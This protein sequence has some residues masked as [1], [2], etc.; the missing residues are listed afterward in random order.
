MHTFNEWVSSKYKRPRCN[1]FHF[2]FLCKF[3]DCSTHCNHTSKSSIKANHKC[4]FVLDWFSFLLF[5]F[6]HLSKYNINCICIIIQNCE[7]TKLFKKR[8]L[9]ISSRLFLTWHSFSTTK[10]QFSDSSIVSRR[11]ISSSITSDSSTSSISSRT[12]DC[13][14]GSKRI[15]DNHNICTISS[16]STFSSK[17]WIWICCCWT[18]KTRSSSISSVS[19]ISTNCWI[20]FKI[21]CSYYKSIHI[22]DCISS[23]STIY[24]SRHSR[25]HTVYYST[26]SISSFQ[27]SFSS[28]SSTSNIS[29]TYISSCLSISSSSST[30]SI[31]SFS[32]ESS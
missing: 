21:F 26:S 16:I 25:T 28:I 19:S 12:I 9:I 14:N 7:C 2:S 13:S 30:L 23:I 15:I 24:T 31:S 4:F 27:Y 22:I 5:F 8:L 10:Y 1:H 29:S 3:C 32:S 20:S 17:K 6:W 18:W 11:S